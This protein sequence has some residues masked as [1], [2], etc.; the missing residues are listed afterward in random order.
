MTQTPDRPGI[1]HITSDGLDQLHADLDR[2]EEVQGEMNERAIDLTRA[3]ARAEAEIERMEIL[4]AAS[5][6]DGQAVR[7]AGRFAEKANEQRARAEQAEAERDRLAAELDNLRHP[8]TFN[9]AINDIGDLYAIHQAITDSG[10][11]LTRPVHRALDALRS[12]WDLALRH[13]QQRK[14]RAEA[15]LTAVRELHDRWEHDANVCAVC[16]DGYGT[17][18]LYPCPTTVLLDQP[19]QTPT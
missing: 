13:E 2:H 11:E 3:L 6:E 14:Q 19:G 9:G 12:R 18:V 5:S 1:D 17:P 15:T 10:G 7:M 8:E 4:V 16:V